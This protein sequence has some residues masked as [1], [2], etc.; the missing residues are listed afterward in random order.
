MERLILTTTV[1]LPIVP[2]GQ[3]I[4]E[5]APGLVL[6]QETSIISR[7]PQESVLADGTLGEGDSAWSSSGSRP[8]AV[9]TGTAAVVVVRGR[10]TTALVVAGILVVVLLLVVVVK[11]TV[12]GRTVVRVVNVVV[13]M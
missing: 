11:A 4:L 8:R 9:W 6:G 2:G 1:S 13:S 12:T 7:G 3:G 10:W 5:T